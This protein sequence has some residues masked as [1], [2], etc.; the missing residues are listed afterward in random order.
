[1]DTLLIGAGVAFAGA[2]VC[3]IVLNRMNH[4]HPDLPIGVKGVDYDY[5]TR[6][7]YVTLVNRSRKTQEIGYTALRQIVPLELAA[8][9]GMLSGAAA[10]R[11][12]TELLSER[13]DVAPLQPREERRIEF[14]K[15]G[16]YRYTDLDIELK[17]MMIPLP[18]PHLTSRPPYLGNLAGVSDVVTEAVTDKPPV[19]VPTPVSPPLIIPEVPERGDPEGEFKAADWNVKVI[20]TPAQ[21]PTI[22]LA[23]I[24]EASGM[25]EAEL[26]LLVIDHLNKEQYSIEDRISRLEQLL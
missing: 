19:N 4:H 21:E 20:D 8:P 25:T 7:F 6:N 26:V 5:E 22:C 17:G 18:N 9:E 14:V 23:R 16:E 2:A 3:K 11:T 12:M 15:M 1:M 10:A 13:S 24:L